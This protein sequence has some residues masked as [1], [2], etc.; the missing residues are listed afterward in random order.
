VHIDHTEKFALGV[1][2]KFGKWAVEECSNNLQ[3]ISYVLGLFKAFQELEQVLFYFVQPALDVVDGALFK[4]EQ[5]PELYRRVQ[6]VVARAIEARNSG[7]WDAAKPAVPVCNFCGAIGRCPKVAEIACSIAK[8]FAPLNVPGNVTPTFCDL[9]ENTSAALNV[10]AVMAIWAQAYRSQVTDRVIRRAAPV[11]P[12]FILASRSVRTVVNPKMARDI[13]LGYLTEE[14]FQSISPF[15]GFGVLE[16][17]IADKSP[18]G[19]KTA[20][21]ESFKADLN[22]SGAVVTGQ[23]YAFLR[24]VSTKKEAPVEETNE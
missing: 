13:S 8:K 2:L 1:D 5:V 3:A 21:M 15:P 17:L 4:R 18:R 20:T 22:G 6:T 23:P 7:S 9:P 19:A 11:P 14:E 10:A 16:K 12:G 24:A